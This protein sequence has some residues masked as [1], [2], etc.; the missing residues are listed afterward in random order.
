[1]NKAQNQGTLGAF[2]VYFQGASTKDNDGK[3][4]SF[5]GQ[6]RIIFLA[7]NGQKLFPI[8]AEMGNNNINKDILV[9]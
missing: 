4:W 9:C 5:E 1:L 8:Y 6:M 3:N 2:I 7:F